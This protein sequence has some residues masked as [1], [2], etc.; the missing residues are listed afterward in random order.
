MCKNG[1]KIS[2]LFFADDT[3]LFCRANRGDLDVI[4]GIL[5]LYEKASCQKLNREKTTVFFSKATSE[6]KK[7]EIIEALG[8]SEVKE[9][10]KY[11]GLPA[12]V[13]R[14]KKASLNFIK[15]SME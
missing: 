13:G 8:V 5:V 7:L 2:H 1:P 12:V 4:Q 9:Y 10:E 6:E 11:L 3:L 14:N 15:E